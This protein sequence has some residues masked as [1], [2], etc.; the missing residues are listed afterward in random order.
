MFF[1]ANLHHEPT[2]ASCLYSPLPITGGGFH[3]VTWAGDSRTGHAPFSSLFAIT[4]G[5]SLP[6][7]RADVAD[8]SDMLLIGEGPSETRDGPSES[9]DGPSETGAD[10]SRP[11]R[12][13]RA[14]QER[15]ERR[16]A[17]WERA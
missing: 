13:G 6:L 4:G 1:H 2:D 10:P 12:D 9:R 16:A 8:R 5:R 14:S 3:G 15:G 7:R 17:G 11:E